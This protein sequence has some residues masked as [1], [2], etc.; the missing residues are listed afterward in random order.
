[1]KLIKTRICNTDQNLGRLMKIAI[2]GPD[3]WAVNFQV[4]EI[5]INKERKEE[6]SFVFLF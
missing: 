6:L 1:M 3:L 2:E 4:L 5:K